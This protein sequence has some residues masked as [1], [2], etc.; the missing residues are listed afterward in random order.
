M[1]TIFYILA[2]RRPSLERQTT[3]YDDSNY[4]GQPN[5]YPEPNVTQVGYMMTG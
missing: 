1:T 4:Y 3:L 5:Y 2:L